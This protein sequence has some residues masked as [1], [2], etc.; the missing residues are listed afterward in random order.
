MMSK[1]VVV[2]V[3]LIGTTLWAADEKARHYRFDKKDVGKLPAGWKSAKTGEGEGSVW[4]LVADDTAPSKSG[5]AL[6]QTAEGPSALFNICVVDE[7]SYQNV[8]AIVDFKAV[9]GAKDQ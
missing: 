4:K 3:L 1:F 2:V 5:V 6:A 9:K 8:E 7:G